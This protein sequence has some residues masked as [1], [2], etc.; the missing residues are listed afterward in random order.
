[1]AENSSKKPSILESPKLVAVVI[2]V[3]ATAIS[4]AYIIQFGDVYIVAFDK[5]IGVGPEVISAHVHGRLIVFIVDN[6]IDFDPE[7]YPQFAF[8]SD[9]IFLDLNKNVH[10]TADG[11]TIAMLLDGLGITYTDRCLILN[12]DFYSF[13]GRLFEKKAY[14]NDSDNIVSFYV[15]RELIS[16]G[17]ADY[18]IKDFEKVVVG[19]ADRDLN[20]VE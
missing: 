14:C 11:A 16:E 20:L 8:A 1:M 7:K 9:Y 3:A 13:S 6:V 4:A 15:N 18:I 19:F 2:I 12:D 17:G 5:P 10:R